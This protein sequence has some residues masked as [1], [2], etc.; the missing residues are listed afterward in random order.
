MHRK[1][2]YVIYT[3]T[4]FRYQQSPNEN[5]SQKVCEKIKS[6]GSII[7]ATLLVHIMSAHLALQLCRKD[8]E[9][10]L[11][12][13]SRVPKHHEEWLDGLFQTISW[14]SWLTKILT[15]EAWSSNYILKMTLMMKI[16]MTKF[17]IQ[18]QFH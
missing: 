2:L 5:V 14:I 11:T 15:K 12:Q 10:S 6:H 16:L 8:L 18:F 3:D 9:M 4:R 13:C 7:V 1:V 17:A